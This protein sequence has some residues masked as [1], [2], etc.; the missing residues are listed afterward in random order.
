MSVTLTIPVSYESRKATKPRMLSTSFGENYSQDAPD[1]L[2]ATPEEWDVTVPYSSS[3]AI[4]A[5]EAV[6]ESAVST[7]LQ[8]T[9]PT[10]GASAKLYRLP[11]QW[12]RTF[13]SYN[14]ETLQFTLRETPG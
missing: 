13:H 10:P 6:L 2:N 14:C 11:D 4:D 9:A 5:I 8:W 3:A 1:G 7:R 12:V